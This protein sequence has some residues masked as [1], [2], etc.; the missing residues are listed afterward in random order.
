VNF[1]GLGFEVMN[2]FLFVE[3][4]GVYRQAELASRNGRVFAV[5]SCISSRNLCGR[6]AWVNN[7]YFECGGE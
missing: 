3:S 4:V 1:V 7:Q 2:Q 5:Y 6:V